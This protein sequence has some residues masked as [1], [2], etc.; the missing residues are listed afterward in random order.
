MNE[1]QF[2]QD[3]VL[4]LY[5]LMDWV[6]LRNRWDLFQNIPA[7][8]QKSEQLKTISDT[9]YNIYAFDFKYHHHVNNPVEQQLIIDLTREL[10]VFRAGLVAAIKLCSSHAE[11]GTCDQPKN[12]Q[13]GGWIYSGTKGSSSLSVKDLKMRFYINT[14]TEHLA[15]FVAELLNTM[16][17]FHE[18]FRFKFANPLQAEALD[19]MRPEKIVLYFPENTNF[20]AIYPFLYRVRQYFDKQVP[21]FVEKVMDGVGYAPHISPAIQRYLDAPTNSYGDTVCNIVARSLLS[22]VIHYSRIPNEKE[23]R[24][25]AD[26][27]YQIIYIQTF[28]SAA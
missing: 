20:K 27:V 24:L 1:E 17:T 7:K 14:K 15:S 6:R 10:E 13:D 16:P 25:I 3:V 5:Y 18:T 19:L 28:R 23:Y 22:F 4:A 21:L 2:K 26:S 12:S 8:F 9:L 11:R